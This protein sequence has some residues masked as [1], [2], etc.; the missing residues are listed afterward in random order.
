MAR[1]GVPIERSVLADWMG[2]TGALIAP[3]V[4]HMARRLM[5]KAPGSMSMR[6]PPRCSIRG[7]ARRKPATSGRY[8]G[9]T[10]AGAAPLRPAWCSTTDPGVKAN[11]QRKSSL[12]SMVRSRSMPTLSSTVRRTRL[13]DEICIWS[14]SPEPG[15]GHLYKA[16]GGKRLFPP[17]V[18][19]VIGHGSLPRRTDNPS[20]LFS[21]GIWAQA[22]YRCPFPDETPTC[23][24]LRYPDLPPFV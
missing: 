8:C 14:P 23:G 18:E 6:Q 5:S 13:S 24:H 2:R 16:Q 10:G 20:R 3:V 7:V 17:Q 9:T 22:A 21:G 15:M 1:H 11:M 4:D 12:A 19:C